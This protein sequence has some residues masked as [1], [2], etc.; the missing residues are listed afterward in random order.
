MEKELL[1]NAAMIF[2][3]E[4]HSGEEMGK[5]HAKIGQLTLLLIQASISVFYDRATLLRVE[6]CPIYKKS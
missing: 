3:S 4:N 1:E 6:K 2:A 5:H